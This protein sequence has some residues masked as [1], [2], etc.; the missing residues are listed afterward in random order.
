MEA[1]KAYYQQQREEM[2]A[3]IP[4]DVT[5]TLEIGCGAGSFSAQIH[6]AYGAET[7]GVEYQPEA[8]A[9][10]AQKLHRVLSGSIEATLPELPQHYFDCIIFND[11]L[12]HLVDPYAALV[13]VQCLLAT[14][15][16]VVA[17]IP[18]IRHWPEFVDYTWRGNW[19]YRD[20]GVLDRTHL[21]FFTQR[22]ILNTLR[23]CG[24]ELVTMQ[25]INPFDSRAQKIATLLT[26][27]RLADTRYKQY[28]IVARTAA[29][30]AH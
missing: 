23:N 3:Y 16:V 15:G 5:R 28:A 24:Y 29:Q 25:G 12:E 6:D 20:D 26:L 11:V 9:L 10:A 17:S 30:P 2:L 21:R 18:N 4:P 27:G 14:N 7:W 1:I 19:N 13:N 8:A 22:S